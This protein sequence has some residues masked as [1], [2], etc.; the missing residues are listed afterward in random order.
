MQLKTIK[1]NKEYEAYLDW[2]GKMFDKKIKPNTAEGEKLKIVLLLIKDYEDKNFP[3]P[4]PNPIEAI[5]L[6]MEE[7]GL[8]N[9]DLVPLIGS[10]SYVS[11]LL[12]GHKPLTLDIVKA[13]HK[14]LG[15]PSDVLL[16]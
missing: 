5:K 9:K 1:T 7:K 3:I 2:V 11:Q 16:A 13:F 4:S 15:I 10:K 14:L 8:K 6:K 12:R